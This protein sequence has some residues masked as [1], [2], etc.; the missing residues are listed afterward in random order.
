MAG[1]RSHTWAGVIHRSL[2]RPSVP[3]W[4][5]ALLHVV[6]CGLNLTSRLMLSGMWGKGA[7]GDLNLPKVLWRQDAF[8]SLLRS[9]VALKSAVPLKWVQLVH[10]LLRTCPFS[11]GC[12]MLWS[13]RVSPNRRCPTLVPGH[14][15]SS[16]GFFQLITS[17]HYWKSWAI[18]NSFLR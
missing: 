12:V 9:L 13:L 16:Y 10:F 2:K 5:G 17:L 6:I 7:G 18:S 4:N 14:F 8:Q 1:E 11:S 3:D 15:A